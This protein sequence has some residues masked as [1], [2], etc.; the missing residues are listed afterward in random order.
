MN[1]NTIS[2]NVSS[3]KTAEGS[4]I[5][6]N[7]ATAAAAAAAAITPTPL[8][9]GAGVMEE[10]AKLGE[11]LG[12]FKA[13]DSQ[14]PIA[15]ITGT[16]IFKC[17]YQA[18]PKTGTKAQENAYVRI[19]T[20]HLTEE[21]IVARVTE[22]SPYILTFLQDLEDKQIKEDHR[23]GATQV[24]TDYMHMDKL[25]EVLE[26]AS[27]SSRLNKDKIEAWFTEKLEDTL[28]DLFS[29][30]MGVDDKSSEAD[31]IRLAQVINA[32][33]AKFAMLA[34]PK[35]GL[36]E[37]DCKAMVKVIESIED[38]RNSVLGARFIAKLSSMNSKA[39]EL[40]LTL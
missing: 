25:I 4:I 10:L 32:Y 38:A 23:K 35:S 34:S 22:L 26:A 2:T 11:T 27:E 15:Q 7:V 14:L 20:K 39:D 17:L 29:V 6:N 30:K 8:S 33:K 21:H 19:P 3:T 28:T 1:T 5:L 18:N 31:I 12:Q 40:L 13:Y 37:E 24:F 16:R 36:K 9:N